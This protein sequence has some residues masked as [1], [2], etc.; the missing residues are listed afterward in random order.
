MFNNILVIPMIRVKDFAKFDPTNLKDETTKNHNSDSM[1]VV[2]VDIETVSLSS[3]EEIKTPVKTKTEKQTLKT[4]KKRSALQS[5]TII[6]NRTPKPPLKFK[7]HKIPEYFHA[8]KKECKQLE[9]YLYLD[10]SI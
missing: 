1:I 4:R 5:S 9:Y 10:I 8:T 7:Y 6:R 3:T 2:P